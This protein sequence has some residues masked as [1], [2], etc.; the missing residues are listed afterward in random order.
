MWCGGCGSLRRNWTLSDWQ[1]HMRRDH[2]E[3]W[4]DPWYREQYPWLF[5]DEATR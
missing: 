3:A 1:A 5:R 2:P 4:A